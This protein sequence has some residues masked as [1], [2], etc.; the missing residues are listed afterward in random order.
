V[1][2][3]VLRHGLGLVGAGVALGILGGGIASLSL[4]SLLFGIS[5]VDPLTLGGS[6]LILLAVAV[7]ASLLPAWRAAKVDPLESLRAE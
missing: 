1:V 4:Q 2:G 5:L 3:L 6:T 7:A